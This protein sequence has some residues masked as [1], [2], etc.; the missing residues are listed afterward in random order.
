MPDIVV[1]NAMGDR[2][3][4]GLEREIA[5]GIDR[6]IFRFAVMGPDPYIF[7][8]FFALLLRRGVN[9]RSTVMHETKTGRFLMELAGRSRKKAVFSF[10]AGFLCHYAMDSTA[11]PWI[12]QASEHR[13]D[14][15]TA[16]EHRLDNLELE[17]QGRQRREIM[18][19]FT[20]FPELPEVQEAMKTV[21]GWDDHCF[22]TA[23]RHMKWYHWIIKDQHGWL[24]F[25]L[26]HIPG[27][28]SAISYQTKR[29]DSIDTSPF[30]ALQE[31]AV[32]MGIRLITAAWQYRMEQISEAELREAI[33]NRS[34]SGGES[35]E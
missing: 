33:G 31:E 23:Y 6:E 21:Y 35:R 17:R 9:R 32:R 1:H 11:H 24:H 20:R 14:L 19:L 3:L 5:E 15:H 8:R 4:Q 22:A 26:H 16:L 12:N 27:G 13:S 28:L 25:L 18:R 7:Y 2:V 10:L 30:P 29:A 34:Y